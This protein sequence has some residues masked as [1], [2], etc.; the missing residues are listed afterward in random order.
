MKIIGV[1]TD[2]VS[3]KRIGAVFNKYGDSFLNKVFHQQEQDCFN[4]LPAHKKN[5]Y[6][7]KRFAAKEALAKAFGT[8]IGRSINFKDIAT[9]NDHLGAPIIQIEKIKLADIDNYNICV[10]LSDD[11]PF[12]VAFVIITRYNDLKNLGS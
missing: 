9:V 1:G 6:L 8:G 3:I 12:A 10:S 5:S 4:K 2:I 7:A 11:D